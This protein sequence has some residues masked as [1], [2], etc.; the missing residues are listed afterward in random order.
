VGLITN[1]VAVMRPCSAR[2]GISRR[3]RWPMIVAAA[4]GC[5]WDDLLAQRW[6]SF[7]PRPRARMSVPP[8]GA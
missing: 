1:D 6:E 7:W 2:A 3:D 4:A 8:P 5:R